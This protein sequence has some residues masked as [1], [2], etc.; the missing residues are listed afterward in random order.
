MNKQITIQI[1]GMNCGS[2]V[3]SIEKVLTKVQGVAKST[4]NL[5]QANAII[6][7]DDSKTSAEKLVEA[8]ENA[9]F[10]ANI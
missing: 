6:S 7:F 10:D 3:A 8:I 5:A 9:G 4:V 2:C 1:Q